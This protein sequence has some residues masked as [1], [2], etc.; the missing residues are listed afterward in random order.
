MRELVYTVVIGLGYAVLQATL[1][2]PMSDFVASPW[3]AVVVFAVLLGFL[4]IYTRVIEPRLGPTTEQL[5]AENDELRTSF[6]ALIDQ[7]YLAEHKRG[8]TKEGREREHA[9]DDYRNRWY[10]KL[11]M[12]SPT[13]HRSRYR[14]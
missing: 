13:P 14:R 11:G 4:V 3:S 7:L 12:K 8:I 5:E 10:E 6:D 9:P 1:G 2:Q